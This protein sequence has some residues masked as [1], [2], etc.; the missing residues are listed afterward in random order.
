MTERKYAHSGEYAVGGLVTSLLVAAAGA[1]ALGFAY[2]YALYY[3]PL[4]YLS[5]LGT[6][7]L[8]FGVGWVS[9]FGLHR[10]HVRNGGMATV[11]GLVASLAALWG[12]WVAWTHAL[13][14]FEALLLSPG[15]IGEL[16]SVVAQEGAWSIFGWTPT[17]A[18]QWGFWIVEALIIVGGGMLMAVSLHAAV[19]YCEDCR[20][21]ATHTTEVGPLHAKELRPAAEAL[22]RGDAG[23]ITALPAARRTA[24][25]YG[26]IVVR[27]CPGCDRTNVAAVELVEQKKKDGK[28]E[29]EETTV[30]DDIS[31]TS[32]DRARLAELQK[33][34][35]SELRAAASSA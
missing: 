35:D 5:V 30:I 8:A 10:G 28:T 25:F 32:T 7:A 26:K 14:E 20:R 17:G 6:L 2:G 18:A 19:P 29:T 4:I 31:L 22:A 27:C 3:V 12:A 34:I 15:S 23:P 9:R 11:V 16:A 1:A 13:V 33:R 21:W 24:A